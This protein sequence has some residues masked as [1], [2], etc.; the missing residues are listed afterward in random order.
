M[1]KLKRTIQSTVLLGIGLGA[2]VVLT[3]LLGGPAWFVAVAAG[4]VRAAGA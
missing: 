1:Q 2:G 3:A 4:Q